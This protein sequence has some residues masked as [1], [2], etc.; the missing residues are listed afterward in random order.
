MVQA[1]Q[2]RRWPNSMLPRLH[3]RITRRILK[4]NF[5]NMRQKRLSKLGCE[6]FESQSWRQQKE[7]AKSLQRNGQRSSI[8][9]EGQHS[10]LF[11]SEAALLSP[12]TQSQAFH[13]RLWA[14][15]P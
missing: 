7:A 8:C 13:I 2:R 4:G 11:L 9:L 1:E 5:L 15:S 10:V 6:Q 3:I 14:D 12:S